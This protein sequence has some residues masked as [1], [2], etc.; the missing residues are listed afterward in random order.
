LGYFKA[1]DTI[2]PVVTFKVNGS[3]NADSGNINGHLRVNNTESTLGTLLL[4]TGTATS[5]P[6]IRFE[7]DTS[8]GYLGFG[9]PNKPCYYNN[10][11]TEYTLWHSGNDGSGSGLDADLLDGKHASEF[12]LA[13]HGVHWEGFTRRTSSY[14]W[15]TLTSANSYTPLFWL[16]STNGGGVAFSDKEGQTSM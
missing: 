16:D 6:R 9:G 14:S 7:G 1:S 11:L 12:A 5:K 10:S 4:I 13:N 8:W 2:N 15:G 3:I